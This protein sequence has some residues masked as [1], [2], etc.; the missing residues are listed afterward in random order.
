ERACRQSPRQAP[1][2]SSC[3]SPD[4]S[5]AWSHFMGK[6]RPTKGKWWCAVYPFLAL[7]AA[8]GESS[9]YRP[10]LGAGT[11]ERADPCVIGRKLAC[12]AG[13]D[14]GAVIQHIGVVG[15]LQTHARILLDQ[16]HG[17]ALGLH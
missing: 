3:R 16:Q 4:W 11:G 5:R 7:L 17:D 6:A 15:N 14:H 12:R 2:A 10:F 9:A 8:I 13:I 1:Q